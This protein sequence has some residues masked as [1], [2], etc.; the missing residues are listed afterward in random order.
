MRDYGV[1]ARVGRW[2]LVLAIGASA[3]A[4][5]SVHT[6]VLVAVAIVTAAATGLLWSDD[7]PIEMR[8]AATVLVITA[9]GLIAWTALQLVP[10]PRGLLGALAPETADV[11][12]RSLAPLNEDG[13]SF[14]PLSLDP[15]A[16]RIQV[17]RGMTYLLAF[18]GALRVA[19]RHEG[20]VFLERAVVGA[21]VAVAAA[22]VMHPFLGARKVLG[23]YEPKEVLAYD[24]QHIGPFLNTN[25][26][27]AFVNIGMLVAF[28]SIIVERDTVPRPIAF[29]VVLLLGA[30]TVWTGS[31]GGTATMLFGTVLVTVLAFRGRGGRFAKVIGRIASALVPIAGAALLLISAFDQTR[32][33][34]LH[35]DL[36][37]VDVAKNGFQ[38]LHDYGVFG[39]GRGAFMSVF[40]KVRVGVD[41][42]VFTDPENVI[43][44]W[45]TEWG[46][47]IA[48]VGMLALAW[49]LR[50]STAL[51][52]SRPPAGAWAALAATAVQNLVDF[53]S[54]IPGVMIAC[55]VAAAIVAGGTS[56][57][58]AT[59]L[60][61]WSRRPRTVALAAGGLALV[62][63]PFIA[64]GI[65]HELYN[66]ERAFREIGLD[67]TLSRDAF[68]ARARAAMLRHPAEPYF[69]FVG[70]VRALVAK[71]E[72][73]VPWMGRALDRSPVYGRAH[74]VLARW[75]FLRSPSQARLEYRLACAQ[76]G[77]LCEM[78]EAFRL[79]SSYE[80]ALQLVPEGPRGFEML[81]RLD[82][83]LADR[84]PSTVVRLDAE[85]A[86]RDPTAVAP[87]RR[88]AL[89]A[90]RDI[91]NGEAWC[92]GSARAGC[93]AEGLDAARRVQARA[94]AKCEGHALTAALRV[95]GDDGEAALAE[96]DAAIDGVDDASTCAREL[97]RLALKLGNRARVDTSLDH[98]LKVRCEAHDCT[99]NMVMAAAAEEQRGGARRALTLTQKAWERSP[100]RDDLLIQIATKAQRQGFH[101]E[102]LDAYTKLDTRHPDDPRWAAEMARERAAISAGV[103]ERR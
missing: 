54:E 45:T 25:H 23:L 18:L 10:L 74:L 40:P 63:V 96:L 35:N 50:P 58:G 92:A 81:A 42:W 14:A 84:L 1:R 102:A 20:V 68:H 34:F 95:A 44:Q 9:V 67:R 103:Y 94:P 62:L 31:R 2:L 15:H 99:D 12:A 70:G 13:P 17:L 89:A 24:P 21:A 61:R 49:A 47:P 82:L 7:E 5:G 80:Q 8:T 73:V 29:V 79:V 33:K 51:V 57:V 85:L 93:V 28:G 55:S 90:L 98:L 71:D 72:S 77:S 59:R 19:H 48:V 3:L 37:K 6:E 52:R 27:A 46:I 4:L 26:L 75:L 78:P 38:L 100:E 41:Y 53:S 65:D 43:V 56:G 97:L 32:E 30:T 91:E 83:A 88:E 101:G 36:M 69:P 22:A 11:W 60:P 64:L 86:Q 39:T 66:E 87:I 16:T 76:D